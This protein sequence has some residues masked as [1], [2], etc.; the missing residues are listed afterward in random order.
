MGRGRI[1]GLLTAGLLVADAKGPANLEY[2]P[3]RPGGCLVL[4]LAR[5]DLVGPLENPTLEIPGL[6]EAGGAQEFNRSRAPPS[7][8]AVDDHLARA[9]QLVNTSRQIAERDEH[10]SRNLADLILLRLSHV[11]N[12]YIVATIE[13]RLQ[14]FNRYF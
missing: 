3:V 8:L 14:L 13:L 9:V 12:K 2:R 6:T 1:I 10:G 11:E 7:H 5:I 4:R